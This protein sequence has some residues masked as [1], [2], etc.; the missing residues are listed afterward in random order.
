[1]K[2]TSIPLSVRHKLIECSMMKNYMTMGAPAKGKNPEGDIMGTASPPFPGEEVIMSIYGG[3]VPYESRRKIKLTSRTVNAIS[4]T[5]MEY[6][7]WSESPITFDWIDHPN[8]IPKP[9]RFPLI[10]HLLIGTTRFTKANM[11]GGSGLNLMYLNTFEG[12]G[13]TRN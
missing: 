6:L 12:L 9:G 7:R 5:T 4:P 2:N 1:M 8:N 3:P 13:L 11:D 10:V